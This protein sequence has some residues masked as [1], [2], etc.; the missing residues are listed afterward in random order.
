MLFFKN[1]IARHQICRN[2]APQMIVKYHL[3]TGTEIL[4]LRCVAGRY[5]YSGK[6]Y[7]ES[8]VNV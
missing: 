1:K 2:I 8:S 3:A 6:V 4:P 7:G 5:Q